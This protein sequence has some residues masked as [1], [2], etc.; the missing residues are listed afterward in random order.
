MK[1]ELVNGLVLDLAALVCRVNAELRPVPESP[2]CIL[3]SHGRRNLT[4]QDAQVERHL[5]VQLEINRAYPAVVVSNVRQNRKAVMDLNHRPRLLD[6]LDLLL[7]EGYLPLLPLFFELHLLDLLDPIRLY[8]LL[9]R[10]G[11]SYGLLAAFLNDVLGDE[12]DRPQLLGG[13]L[14][15][16]LDVGLLDLVVLARVH[17]CDPLVI[18]EHGL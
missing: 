10:N 13:L 17:F 11:E 2:S 16:G 1:S 8:L 7:H 6:L 3:L 5:A 12:L 15:D 9:S 4:D 18:V 14:Q